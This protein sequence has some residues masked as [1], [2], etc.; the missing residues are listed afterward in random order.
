MTDLQI[1]PQNRV[2]HVVT[3]SKALRIDMTP[4]V[5][6]GFLLIT[7]FIFNTV[8]T[9]PSAMHLLLPVEGPSTPFA[10]TRT[11]TVLLADGGNAVCYEGFAQQPSGIHTVNLF[12]GQPTLR[13]IIM[14]KQQ[15]LDKEGS[16]MVI[17]KPGLQS[18]YKQLVTALD[19]M[20]ICGIQKYTV[21]AMDRADE[22]L[23]ETAH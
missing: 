12:S 8:V 10:A 13:N 4:M 1:P 18:S 22:N 11:L 21:S 3:A 7:F 15:A 17:I 20:T 14:Q 19:E 5:D 2:K 23:L 16:L 9:K 6:L